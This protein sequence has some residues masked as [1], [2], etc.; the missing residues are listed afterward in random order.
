[1][2]EEIKDLITE[3]TI[4][5]EK[6]FRRSF[7]YINQCNFL[8]ISNHEN[9]MNINNE[10]RR[11]WI[12]KI[13]CQ[14]M[15]DNWWKAKWKWAEEGGA[16]AVLHHLKTLTIKNPDLYKSRAPIT[17]DFTEM[18]HAS[19]HPIFKWLDEHREAESG[20]FKRANYFRN[21]NFM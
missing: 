11:Y 9:S 17:D 1:M 7:D 20:P 4:H 5:I 15:D 21:F 8:L 2:S 10:E 19:E 6:K 16:K 14:Q 18:A 3:P 12:K 13:E